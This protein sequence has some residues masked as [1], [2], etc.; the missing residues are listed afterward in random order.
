MISLPTAPST[1][2]LT[3]TL[4]DAAINLILERHLEEMST[5]DLERFFRDVYSDMLAD[6]SDAK[7][8]LKLE[9]VATPEELADFNTVVGM[10]SLA[11]T[12]LFD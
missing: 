3:P 10:V 11:D 5:K 8:T 6:Y 2:L 1:S 4:R 12:D 9:E 7:L